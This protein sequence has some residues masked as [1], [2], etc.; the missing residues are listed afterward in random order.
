MIKKYSELKT[1]A[2]EQENLQSYLVEFEK[3]A[4]KMKKPFD[5]VTVTRDIL[6]WQT[7]I[8][9]DWGDIERNILNYRTHKDLEKAVR[10]VRKDAEFDEECKKLV[11]KGTNPSVKVQDNYSLFSVN[12]GEAF[13]VASKG[14]K[15]CTK[16]VSTA[17][18][19]I[20]KNGTPYILKKENETLAVFFPR[21]NLLCWKNDVELL[22]ANL[23]KNTQMS[24]LGLQNFILSNISEEDFNT[25]Q[26]VLSKLNMPVFKQNPY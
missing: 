18:D 26:I 12:N 15:W 17:Y 3:R 9:R 11:E 24:L 25:L 4:R 5:P 2:T 1:A 8:R 10:Y 14:T 6:R 13:S 23:G 7:A 19:F 20:K 16:D 22:D 21:K